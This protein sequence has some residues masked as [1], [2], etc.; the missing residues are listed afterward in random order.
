MTLHICSQCNYETNIKKNF[1]RH[2]STKKH[3]SRQTLKKSEE[4]INE[5]N[6]LKNQVKL[7]ETNVSEVKDSIKNELKQDINSAIRKQ[8]CIQ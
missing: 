6:K 7:V 5:L 3:I 1:T 8:K 4:I 2:L